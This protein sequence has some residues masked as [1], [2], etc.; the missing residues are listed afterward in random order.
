MHAAAPCLDPAR[1]YSAPALPRHRAYA[2]AST[3][4][5]TVPRPD[6][7]SSTWCFAPSDRLGLESRRPSSPRSP[8]LPRVRAVVDRPR[9]PDSVV[10]RR[11]LSRITSASAVSPCRASRC[12][13]ASESSS[14]PTP[15]FVSVFYLESGRLIRFLLELFHGKIEKEEKEKSEVERNELENGNQNQSRYFSIFSEIKHALMGFSISP[16]KHIPQ[17]QTSW[18]GFADWGECVGVILL[19]DVI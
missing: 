17:R 14:A 13:L 1:R 15:H 9:P 5:A 11:A 4:L 16:V 6:P 7:P 10:A 12:R 8:A 18:T 19:P 2:H 3:P